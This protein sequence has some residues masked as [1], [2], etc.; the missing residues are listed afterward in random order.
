M[1]DCV[2]TYDDSN[3]C[4]ETGCNNVSA[5]IEG[6]PKDN[7]MKYCPYCGRKLEEIINE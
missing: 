2:W 1:D 6:T 5:V 7:G 4:W 3:D